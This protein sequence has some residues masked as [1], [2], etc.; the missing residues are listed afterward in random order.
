[1]T[2]GELIHALRRFGPD[3]EI[4]VRTHTGLVTVDDVEPDER[5]RVATIDI[6]F[7]GP[8]PDEEEYL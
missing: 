4:A 5:E 1:M 8:L 3:D 2:V 6:R 7:S